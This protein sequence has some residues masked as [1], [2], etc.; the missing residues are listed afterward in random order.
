MA[1]NIIT[2]EKNVPIPPQ[3]V[4]VRTG[5]SKYKFIEDKMEP[6]D[7]CVINGNTPDI[8]P[9]SLRSWVYSRRRKART[10][11]LKRRRY[12][13][14]TLTG[15]SSNPTSIRVWRVS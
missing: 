7:S 4:G 8:T 5:D 2:I 6:G 9:K 12:A 1:D 11:A 15:T 10:S 3:M 14:R 13:I